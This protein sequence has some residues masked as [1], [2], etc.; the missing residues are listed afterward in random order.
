MTK[1][2]S[3]AK[4]RD[5]VPSMELADEPVKPSSRRDRLRVEAERLAGEGPGA[6]RR[7]ARH[8]RVPV[9]QPLDVAQQR[10]RV[11]QQVVRQEH[12]LGVL[13][14]RAPGHHRG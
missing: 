6:V 11:G 13:E 3:A 10:P 1:A 2:N 7:V 8:A 5:A 4:S 12:G 14:V 9:A